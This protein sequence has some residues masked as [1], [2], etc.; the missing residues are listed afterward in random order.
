MFLGR[1]LRRVPAFAP[2]KVYSTRTCRIGIPL[3]PRRS[4]CPLSIYEKLP[5][6]AMFFWLPLARGLPYLDIECKHDTLFIVTLQI[7]WFLNRP[8]R[9]ILHTVDGEIRY[10]G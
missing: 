7:K 4:M 2:R 3:D 8:D 1:E 9:E 10:A 5:P 6:C